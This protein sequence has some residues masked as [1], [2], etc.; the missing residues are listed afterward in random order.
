MQTIDVITPI[1]NDPFTFG[2]ISAVNS[3]SDVYAMGGKPVTALAFC[4][5]PARELDSCVLRD[6]LDGASQVLRGEKVALIGGHSIE[7]GELKFGLSVTG[8]VEK[9]NILSSKGAQVGDVIIITKPIG[10]GILS[11]ALKGRKITQE[12]F[13]IAIRWMTMLNKTASEA[14]LF[15]NATACTDVTGFGLLGHAINMVKGL[16]IDFMIDFGSV[17]LLENVTEMVDFGMCPEGTYRNL[18]FARENTIFNTA[19][20][21][22]QKLIL[23]DPQ[24]SGG[25]LITLKKE[26]LKYFE[27]NNIFYKQ[28]GTVI[29]GS[30]KIVV[31]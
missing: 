23:S 12:V 7:D 27:T 10:N 24:T 21:E 3:L 14:A 2:V 8:V 18:N 30:G 31:Y 29:E 5:F 17:P 20:S 9:K 4:G 13:D 15:S 19:I 22:E 6:I 11:T 16:P 25:L 28:V 26:Y 1:V